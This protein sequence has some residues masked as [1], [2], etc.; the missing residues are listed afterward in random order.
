MAREEE[1]ERAVVR[2][3]GARVREGIRAVLEE[4]LQEEITEHPK[5]GYRELTSPA[6]EGATATISA[7]WWLPQAR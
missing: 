7:T 5:A 6:W 2:D 3:V 4:I 1:F